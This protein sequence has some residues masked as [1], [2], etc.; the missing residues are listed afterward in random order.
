M[1]NKYYKELSKTLKAAERNARDNFFDKYSDAIGLFDVE[2]LF[3]KQ[4]YK[5]IAKELLKTCSINPKFFN[6][7]N[8]VS[9]LT[10]QQLEQKQRHFWEDIHCAPLS[11]RTKYLYVNN[12][13][14][15]VMF[16]GIVCGEIRDTPKGIKAIIAYKRLYYTGKDFVSISQAVANIEIAIYQYLCKHSKNNN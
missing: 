12:K 11:K 9:S 16:D 8:Q 4:R 7:H 15:A 5:L 10:P 2:R 13:T 14:T 3:K 1:S 6:L